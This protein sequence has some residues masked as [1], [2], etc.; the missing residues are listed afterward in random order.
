MFKIRQTNQHEAIAVVDM[1]MQL[2]GELLRYGHMV[3]PGMKTKDWVHSMVNQALNGE[4]LSLVAATLSG[5]LIGTTLVLDGEFPYNT[6]FNKPAFGFGTY[7]DP[8]WRKHGVA[9]A[10]YARAKE[11]LEGQGYDMYIGSYL[12]D[13]KKSIS[14]V[15]DVGFEAYEANVR[16]RLNG[17]E[18]D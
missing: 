17:V 3:Q 11:T 7:V 5:N 13:N 2:H 9:H 6:D 18:Y 14:V 15:S 16:M 1:F 12:L 10:L 4:G 8:D